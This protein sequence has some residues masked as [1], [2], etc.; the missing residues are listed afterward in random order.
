MQAYVYELT[1]QKDRVLTL[2]NVPFT[3]GE[4]I[5]VI[6]IRRSQ[7]RRDEKN[8]YPFWGK[9]LTYLDPTAPIAQDDWEA[10]Q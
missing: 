5:E 6:L 4:N 10:L 7:A 9:P 2:D 3:A 1:M 8:R